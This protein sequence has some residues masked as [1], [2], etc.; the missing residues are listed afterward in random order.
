MDVVG[1]TVGAREL[2]ELPTVWSECLLGIT[3]ELRTSGAEKQT[4]SVQTNINYCDY[5]Q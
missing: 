4:V 5:L 3:Q 1:L 2:L